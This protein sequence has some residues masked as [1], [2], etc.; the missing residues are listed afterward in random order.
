MLKTVRASFTLLFT[1]N[2]KQMGTH[3]FIGKKLP[4]GKVKYIEVH[5]D[6]YFSWTGRIL[7][8]FYRTEK[9]VDALLELGSLSSIGSTPYG[10]NLMPPKELDQIHCRA[11]I[12]DFGYTDKEFLPQTA[13]NKKQFFDDAGIAY[14][15]EDGKWYQ[16]CQ[17]HI[18]DISSCLLT[19][20]EEPESIYPNINRCEIYSVNTDST[21]QRLKQPPQF[22][23]LL[24][25][26]ATEEQKTF[27]VFR[28]SQLIKI[29]AP[30]VNSEKENIIKELQEWNKTILKTQAKPFLTP[31][32]IDIQFSDEDFDDDEKADKTNIA[33]YKADSI[34][35]GTVIYWINFPAMADYFISEDDCSSEAFKEQVHISI[36]HEIGHALF[37]KFFD[38]YHEGDDEYDQLIDSFPEKI[39]AS[40]FS[41]WNKETEEKLVEEFAA[42]H[43][44]NRTE[45][46]LLFQLGKKIYNEP[47]NA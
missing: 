19:H 39:I 20:Y 11:Y 23:S 32:D 14:L 38:W 12:R 34:L 8:T 27:Y 40:L 37:E 15:Y 29:V 9:R 35:E 22:W 45:E 3:A 5:Y 30:A 47:L 44:G 24:E 31:L 42:L 43:Y 46:S 18:Q 4:D 36:F 10:K 26:L 7:R 1:K 6:G 28:K 21:L 33:L 25:E 17:K 13:P 16:S 41:N 2:S